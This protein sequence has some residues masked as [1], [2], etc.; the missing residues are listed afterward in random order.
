MEGKLI[1]FKLKKTLNILKLISLSSGL[2]INKI[3]NMNINFRVLN[4]GSINI[5]LF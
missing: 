3:L 4:Y 5:L 1:F 2:I